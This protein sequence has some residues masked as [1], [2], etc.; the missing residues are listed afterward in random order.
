MK[1][2]ANIFRL[3]CEQRNHS[4]CENHPVRLIEY[5]DRMRQEEKKYSQLL[6]ELSEADWFT[7]IISACDEFDQPDPNKMTI[8]EDPSSYIEA[9]RLSD[10]E[11]L[12]GGDL[13]LD[14]VVI[15]KNQPA[16][17]H[18]DKCSDRTI[19]QQ[20]TALQCT[21]PPQDKYKSRYEKKEAIQPVYCK[22][23]E[24]GGREL[25]SWETIAVESTGLVL[26]C[27]R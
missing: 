11:I 20:S 6:S 9:T 12:Y 18:I 19:T 8:D 22:S 26:Y 7:R 23:P 14:R 15:E 2:G 3:Q 10:D 24:T 17:S 13:T 1:N 21:L 4:V 5:D 27:W 16:L 25:L